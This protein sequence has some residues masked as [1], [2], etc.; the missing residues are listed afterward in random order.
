MSKIY[1]LIYENKV[2]EIIKSEGIFEDIPL[3]QRYTKEIVDNCVECDETVKEGMD[4]NSETGEFT[5]HVEEI[6]EEL[7]LE[8]NVEGA[9]ENGE[10]K[11]ETNEVGEIGL[12]EEEKQEID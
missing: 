8:E 9:E 12:G 7:P 5:E 6:V 2:K 4:Y 1:A 10:V 11:D 3:E